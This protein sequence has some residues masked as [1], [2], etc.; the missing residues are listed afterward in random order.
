MGSP[1]QNLAGYYFASAP[2]TFAISGTPVVSD[3]RCNNAMAKALL[4]CVGENDKEKVG[5]YE[6]LE[7]EANRRKERKQLC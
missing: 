1:H 3:C 4:L 2:S 5:R 7:V 6:G